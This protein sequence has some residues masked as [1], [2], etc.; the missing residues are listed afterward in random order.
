VFRDSDDDPSKNREGK[1]EPFCPYR[2]FG[3]NSYF[4]ELECISGATRHAT[5]RCERSGCVL[6]LRK[7]DFFELICEFPQFGEVW[8]SAAGRRESMR[9]AALKRLT[10]RQQY[11]TLAVT[12]IQ[13]V[14]R[15]CTLPIRRAHYPELDSGLIKMDSFARATVLQVHRTKDMRKHMSG[16]N[17]APELLY[18]EVRDMR[19]DLKELRQEF[20]SFLRSQGGGDPRGG[21]GD[22]RLAA[23]VTE[24]EVLPDLPKQHARWWHTPFLAS[25]ASQTIQLERTDPDSSNDTGLSPKRGQEPC[26]QC[27]HG[28][29]VAHPACCDDAQWHSS[30]RMA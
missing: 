21:N 24:P 27:G 18:K 8:Q 5:A 11:R 19:T 3:H 6:M 2:L 16:P 10:H 15:S 30:P 22:L 17:S 28:L 7:R 26:Q 29:A 20:R 4:G 9:L 12:T 14:F 25:C 23:Q 13:R 1:L